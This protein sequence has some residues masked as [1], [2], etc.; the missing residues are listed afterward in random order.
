MQNAAGGVAEASP[1]LDHG[2]VTGPG[3]GRLG[4]AAH[5]A[6]PIADA[7][8]DVLP[9]VVRGYPP[10]ALVSLAAPCDSTRVEASGPEVVVV[11]NPTKVDLAD[12]R[13]VLR[14]A[15]A[16]A[17]VRRRGWSRRPKTIPASARPATPFATAP[18][19]C[20]PSAATAPSGRWPRSSSAPACA[21]GLLPGG[22]GNLLARNLGLPSTPWPT[23]PRGLLR[24]GPHDRRRL[25]GRRPRREPAR[26]RPGHQRTTSTASPSW[27]GSASTPRSWKTRPKA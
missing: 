25:V 22:T 18:S 2:M 19:W 11:V 6:G 15:A 17:G 9:R 24:S 27:P 1:P 4:R 13:D 8:H 23:R 3:C 16:A 14:D 7:V 26:W 21:L 12:V 20:A 10:P 5:V